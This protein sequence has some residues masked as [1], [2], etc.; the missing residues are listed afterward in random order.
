ML[1][2]ITDSEMEEQERKTRE[3]VGYLQKSVELSRATVEHSTVGVPTSHCVFPVGL[4]AF[5]RPRSVKPSFS[6]FLSPFRCW[7]EANYVFLIPWASYS[8]S[9]ASFT[10]W[11]L[12]CN[13]ADLQAG[14]SRVA[15]FF[16]PSLLH[17]ASPFSSC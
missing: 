3:R 7:P 6:L 13:V 10:A 2:V 15:F 9:K 12:V 4:L 11:L 16:F 17:S 14:F 8:F 1:S 5:L